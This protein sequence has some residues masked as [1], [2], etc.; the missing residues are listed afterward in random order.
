MAVIVSLHNIC[1]YFKN[2]FFH[3][4]YNW[5]SKSSLTVLQN[6]R[7]SYKYKRAKD[8]SLFNTAAPA[9]V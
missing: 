4:H 3:F 8:N 7:L 6:I 9:N 2:I 1:I 5:E